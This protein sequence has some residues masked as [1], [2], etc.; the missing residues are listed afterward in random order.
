MSDFDRNATVWG[1][2]S[3][4]RAGTAEYDLGLRS[5]MLGIYNHMTLALA[6]SALVATGSGYSRNSNARS[7]ACRPGSV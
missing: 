2:T 5:Y 4:A 3:T 7:A 6:I 1:R